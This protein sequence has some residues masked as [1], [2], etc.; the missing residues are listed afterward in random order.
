MAHQQEQRPPKA[1]QNQQAGDIE[2]AEPYARELIAELGEERHADRDQEHHRP[3][4]RQAE[5]LLFITAE[6]LHLVD[7]RGLERE[8][9]QHGDAENGRDVV[10]FEA[11]QRHDVGDVNH[12]PDQRG[13][14]ELDHPHGAGEHDRRIGGDGRLGGDLERGLGQRLRAAGGNADLI[15][16]RGDGGG[17]THRLARVEFEHDLA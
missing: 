5:I 3:G 8:H 2:A 9:R 4:R 16:G 1:D 11:V 6:R 14:R 10:P 17:R 13:E 7:V 12:E 15:R